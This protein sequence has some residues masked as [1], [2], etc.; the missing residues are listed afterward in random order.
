MANPPEAVSYYGLGEDG[1]ISICAT[2][3]PDN[4]TNKH[5][6]FSCSDDNILKYKNTLYYEEMSWATYTQ[7]GLGTVTITASTQ[8][9]SGKS[10]SQVITLFPEEFNLNNQN[11]TVNVGSSVQL[12]PNVNPIYTTNYITWESYSE[13]IARVDENGVVMG[14]S[15]GSATI[16]AKL[17]YSDEVKAICT[18]TVLSDDCKL[19]LNGYLDG[20]EQDSLYEYGTVDVY[21][22]GSL[23]A[24]DVFDYCTSWPRGTTYEITDIKAAPGYQCDGVNKGSLSGTIGEEYVD[25]R[26]S[27]STKS[28][29]LA[30]Y[31]GL[32]D[33]FKQVLSPYGTADVYING[34]LVADDVSDYDTY[35]PHG[36]AYEITDIKPAT[37]YQ[38]NGVYSGSLTGTINAGDAVVY[39]NF[40]RITSGIC[41]DNATWNYQNGT[42]TI[43]GSGR[44]YDYEYETTG[45]WRLSSDFITAVVV[46]KG[47]T[48][49]GAGSFN[50]YPALTSVSL[51]DTLTALGNEA[52]AFCHA[53]TTINLP[54][55]LTDMGEGVFLENTS[56]TSIVIPSGVIKIG[57]ASFMDCENLTSVSMSNGI[58]SIEWGAFDGCTKLNSLTIPSSV[59][60]IDYYA[61]DNCPSLT[62]SCYA[63]TAAHRHAKEKNIPYILQDTS[64]GTATVTF[65]STTRQIKAHALRNTKARRVMVSE[66]VTAIGS[67]A[68]ENCAQLEAIYIP[69]SCGSI[70][71]DAFSGV[72]DLVI[73]GRA[74]SYAETYARQYGFDFVAL[75][76]Q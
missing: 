10:A 67:G 8:D 26:L 51:P 16:C 53:L 33:Q 76:G 73:Y 74:G 3:W 11:V 68:F 5:I 15:P 47:I 57:E 41:G 32:D 65:P 70:A 56:L 39:L 2:I 1:E 37:G 6:S 35:W 4:A 55:S 27:F 18:V 46:E 48:Y 14:V 71:A 72:T 58:T 63:H 43:S 62:I 64:F 19:D 61:F 25:I 49:I 24:D 44:M 52:F 20:I 22:N 29:R 66:G 50:Y 69:Y 23:V 54:S 21:I 38:Y 13:Y 40:S 75:S 45:P 34:S 30:L 31:G 17:N 12:V 9:G 59:E 28:Y 7:V 42:L 60:Y 36:T